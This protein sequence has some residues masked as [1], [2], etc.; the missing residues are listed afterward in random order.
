PT[1]MPRR[2]ASAR[3]AATIARQIG[4]PVVLKVLSPDISHKSDVGGVV[5]GLNSAAQV[6]AAFKLIKN[7]V[8]EKAPSA[9]FDG[10]AVQAM[11]KAGVEMLAGISYDDAFGPMLVAGLGGVLV[12]VVRDVVM[13]PVPI[14]PKTGRRMLDEMSG[15]AILRGVRGAPPADID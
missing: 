10:V 6:E 7:N 13:R 3:E 1:A 9:R 8:A 14:D 2:A 12:A 4:F 5:L 15:A 11:A